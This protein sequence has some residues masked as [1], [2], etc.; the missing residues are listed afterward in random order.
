[1]ISDSDVKIHTNLADFS[2]EL[3]QISYAG[4]WLP[5]LSGWPLYQQK[6]RCTRVLFNRYFVDYSESMHHIDSV[7]CVYLI[8]NN[9]GSYRFCP[10][11]LQS[12]RM[13]LLYSYGKILVSSPNIAC[14]NKFSLHIPPIG[15]RDENYLFG[16][17]INSPCVDFYV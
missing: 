9:R 8:P 7:T 13:V 15:Q 11:S 14:S 6:L 1:M 10:T 16:I 2:A 12:A 3:V 4:I 17:V 5:F